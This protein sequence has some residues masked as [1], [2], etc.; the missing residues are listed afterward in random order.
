[1]CRVQTCPELAEENRR[2]LSRG[3]Q[4]NKEYILRLWKFGLKTPGGLKQSA[5]YQET[6]MDMLNYCSLLG[7]VICHGYK[8]FTHIPTPIHLSLFYKTELLFVY[9]TTENYDLMSK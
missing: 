5:V 4:K 6:A 9:V 8:I 3:S 7:L 1:M 2:N